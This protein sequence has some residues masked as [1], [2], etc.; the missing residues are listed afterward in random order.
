MNI[1][2]THTS[3]EELDRILSNNFTPAM[4]AEYLKEERISLRSFGEAL[5]EIY[6]P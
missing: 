3:K 1:A 5:Q 4:A 2:L 6:L